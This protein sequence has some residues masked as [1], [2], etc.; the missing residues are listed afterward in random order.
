M[1]AGIAQL[2]AVHGHQ[3]I[4]ADPMPA[5]ID[6][7]RAR[8]GASLARDVEKKRL[9]VAES[10]AA[11][12]RVIS[13]P[14]GGDVQLAAFERCGLVIEAII[15]DLA[16]KRALFGSLERVTRPGTVLATNT[17]SLSVAAI[18]SAC[19][20]AG[21]VVGIHFFNPAPVMPL[22][23]IVAAITTDAAIAAAARELVDGW[24][25]TT[26]IASDTPGF[27]VNR[28]ARPF[29][30]ESLRL[31]EEGV[32]DCATIDWALRT[33][34]GFRMGP[35]ELMD[36]IGNDINHAVTNSVF[37]AMYFDARYRPEM[38]GMERNLLLNQLDTSW[39]N[40]LYTMDHLRSGIGLVSYAQVD[41][42]TEYKRQGMKEFESMWDG[43]REKVTETV[44]RM[45][46]EDSFQESVWAIGA[47]IHESA[48]RPVAGISAEQQAAIANS[49]KADKKAEPIRNQGER[50][51]RNDPCHCGSGKKYK[52]CHLR[53]AAV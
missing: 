53:Q 38:R 16:A 45:E 44:F 47:M 51:G 17:S 6:R 48:P 2:A 29:Y 43:V 25:K 36:F 4:I 19:V 40:H 30:G 34:G 31:L 26:V 37:E 49:G 35:F 27:I 3:V 28:I 39:K 20:D 10:E 18:G 13:T 5:A 1:G 9:T 7:A 12:A 32:A 23:E 41:P 14:G 50:I 52:N 24:G 33:I 22:V 42:K 15:E 46:E 8:I 11:I 21:R